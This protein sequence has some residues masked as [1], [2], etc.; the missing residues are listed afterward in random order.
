MPEYPDNR[1]KFKGVAPWEVPA[2]SPHFDNPQKFT[3]RRDPMVHS[4]TRPRD[5]FRTATAPKP[6]EPEPAP[7]A[8][9]VEPVPEQKDWEL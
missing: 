2:A 8:P 7:V 6:P 5:A 3:G 1:N 4:S 9:Y